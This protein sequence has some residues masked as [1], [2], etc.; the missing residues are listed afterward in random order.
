MQDGAPPHIA[1]TVKQLLNLHFGNGRIISR[2]FLT[3]WPPRSPDLNP[4]DFWLWRLTKRCC[5]RESNCE[6]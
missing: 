5:V 3:A 4:C 1:A 6:L 2:H